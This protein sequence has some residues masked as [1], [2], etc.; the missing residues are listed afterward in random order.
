MAASPQ[1]SVS[2]KI[3]LPPLENG[4]HLDQKTFHA[5]Y[6]AMGENVRAELIGGIVY[7]AS[8]QKNPHSRWHPRVIRWL[9]EYEEATPGIEL[10]L[11]ATDILGPDSELQSDACLIILEEFGGQTWEDDEDYLHGPAELVVEVAS[12]TESIDLN[13]KKKEFEKA[14]VKE[15]L[16]IAL[17]MKKVFWFIRR[18]G[19]FIELKPDVDGIYRSQV[20]PGL[21]LD[22]E[23][24]LRHD[25]KALL[26]VL[27]EGLASPAH[28]AF[29]AK[30]IRK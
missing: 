13:R 6:E 30:M 24:L 8:P 29:V 23:A 1:K 20:F 9:D 14:G 10:L 25:R 4:D 18:R 26:R 16:V 19:K 12:A 5:R 15:Y 3:K 28:A 21:W 27:R 2:R 7:M 17:R 22:V 11:N